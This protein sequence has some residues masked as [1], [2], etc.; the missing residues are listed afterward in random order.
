[1]G[2]VLVITCTNM[3]FT[4]CFL[5]TYSIVMSNYLRATAEVNQ[6]FA[7]FVKSNI[8]YIIFFGIM[9]YYELKANKIMFSSA[10]KIIRLVDEQNMIFNRLPDGAMIFK[11]KNDIRKLRSK[12]MMTKSRKG[13]I[14]NSDP[15]VMNLNDTL[16]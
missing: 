9:T 12:R 10:R 4:I 1:M 8:F 13:Q 14:T 6:L 7:V 15:V 5:L 16:K 3:L 2:F 11:S